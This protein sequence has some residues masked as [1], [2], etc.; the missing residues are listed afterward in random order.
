MFLPSPVTDQSYFPA[1]T[2]ALNKKKHAL[3]KEKDVSEPR[4]RT[5]LGDQ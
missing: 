1:R 3:N 2:R 4:V 5:G